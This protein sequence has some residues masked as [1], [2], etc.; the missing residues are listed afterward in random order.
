MHLSRASHRRIAQLLVLCAWLFALPLLAQP[1]GRVA[2]SEP[3]LTVTPD[4]VSC[5]T[6]VTVRGEH[7]VPGSEV[8]VSN[9]GPEDVP[10]SIF[11]G[12]RGPVTV[13]D[14]GTF[15]IDDYMPSIA[16]CIGLPSE[17]VLITASTLTEATGEQGQLHTGQPM[18]TTSLTFE[19]DP[20]DPRIT[21]TPDHGTG[22]E[23]VTVHGEN[24][25]PGTHVFVTAG[26]LG[27]HT[28]AQVTSN[29]YPLVREDGTFDAALPHLGGVV[30]CD[31]EAIP[32]DGSQYIVGVQT[33]RPKQSDDPGPEPSAA[34][35]FTITLSP[36]Q[37]FQQTWERTDAA[38]AN[39]EASRTWIWGPSFTEVIEEPY[40]DSPGGTRTVQYFDKARMEINDPDADRTNPWYVTNGLLVVEMVEGKVQTGDTQFDE[41]PEPA[42]IPIAGD[43]GSTSP[44]YAEINRL[45]LTDEP[46]REPGTVIDEYIYTGQSD[47]RSDAVYAAYGLT[48]TRHVAETGHSIASVFWDFMNS[49]MEVMVDT[50]YSY[51]VPLFED[52]FY[53]TGY[54]ITEAYWTTTFVGGQ[55]ADVL[56]QCFE[57]RCLTYTPSNIDGW[58]VEAGNVGQHYFEWR[59][60]AR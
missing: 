8:I 25:L 38:V 14:D 3:T 45:R 42:D 55:P 56:W 50:Q 22:C 21:L 39:G 40:A 19:R 48:A 58:K 46:A 20:A 15:A 16:E 41:S 51:M 60:P 30:G 53:A 43:H 36:A 54:P 37:R 35:I 9:G 1:A 18:V 47:V 29:D 2:A 4:P 59:Y 17:P 33:G 52:P 27:G 26:G 13:D 11:Q 12:F 7:F 5:T 32:R 31:F 6:R 34:H 28:F 24:F 57:R 23:E 49:E 44:T 10:F